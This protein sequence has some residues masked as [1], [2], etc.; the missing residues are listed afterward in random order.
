MENENRGCS[1]TISGGLTTTQAAALV[2]VSAKTVLA[3]IACGRLPAVKFGR[4]WQIDIADLERWRAETPAP[5]R[6]SRSRSKKGAL[7]RRIT[8]PNLSL[9]ERLS[10]ARRL[11]RMSQSQLAARAGLS[12]AALSAMEENRATPTVDELTRIVDALL[13]LPGPGSQPPSPSGED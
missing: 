11:R 13:S 2:G 8:S 12:L 4:D 7:A 1:T 6:P 10:L 3:A 9:G 5:G